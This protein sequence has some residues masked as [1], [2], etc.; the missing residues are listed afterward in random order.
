[1]H[2]KIKISANVWWLFGNVWRLVV[3]YSLSTFP[4][5][6]DEWLGEIFIAGIKTFRPL[7]DS[8]PLVPRFSK[9]SRLF[10]EGLIIPSRTPPELVNFHPERIAEVK[11]AQWDR[12]IKRCTFNNP[13]S[14][15]KLQLFIKL[16]LLTYFDTFCSLNQ[17]LP[18]NSSS[19]LSNWS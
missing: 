16:H 10:T 6:I 3:E 7:P 1:M 4:D 17:K 18:N 15:L 12:G 11:K 2:L 19:C 9:R 13:Y 8:P 5:K 14:M